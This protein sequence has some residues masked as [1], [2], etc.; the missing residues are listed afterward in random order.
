M[1]LGALVQITAGSLCGDFGDE[2]KKCALEFARLG[3]LDIVSSDAHSTGRRQPVVSKGLRILEDEIG[4]QMVGE[5]VD[6]S[7]KVIGSSLFAQG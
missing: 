1:D 3:V 4:A 7:Y 5:I 6:N 2:A